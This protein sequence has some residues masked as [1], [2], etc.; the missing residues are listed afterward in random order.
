MN[1]LFDKIDKVKDS[2]DCDVDIKKVKALRKVLIGDKDIN[3]LLAEYHR[4]PA[5]I[6]KRKLF[7]N[8]LFREY[9]ESE[10]KVNLLILEINAKL[11]KINSKGY[12]IK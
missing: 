1:E 6:L 8:K 4:K 7:Q 9:K 12:C 5:L 11:K 10:G 3:S 2:L